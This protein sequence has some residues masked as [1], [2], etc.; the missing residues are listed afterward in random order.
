[1]WRA[2]GSTNTTSSADTGAYAALRT[3]GRRRV[4]GVWGIWDILSCGILDLRLVVKNLRGGG[5]ASG[6][7]PSMPTNASSGTQKW[8]RASATA[9]SL[10]FWIRSQLSR[11]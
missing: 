6:R 2:T 9:C 4:G 5:G 8:C 3:E 1:M 10:P 11:T 7:H